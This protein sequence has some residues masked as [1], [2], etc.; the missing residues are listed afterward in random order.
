MKSRA[1]LKIGLVILIGSALAA[2]I[3]FGVTRYYSRPHH[4]AGTK[5]NLNGIK[6]KLA[7]TSDPKRLLKKAGEAEGRGDWGEALTWYNLLTTNLGEQ[8]PR[9]GFVYYRKAYC[10]F[11]L[12][13]YPKART[14]MEYGLN[15]CRDMPQLDDALFLMA[16]I[17]SKIGDFDL[18][19]KTYNT[20]IKMFPAR[21]EEAK[22]LQSQL[23]PT[24]KPQQ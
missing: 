7:Y 13:D 21:S 20:I 24:Q 15:H 1:G 18:T 10:L 4:P 11:Q 16:R 5:F 19:N 14:A 9:K 8:D 12:G 6:R 2:G 3:Y 17:Y 22:K 23:P